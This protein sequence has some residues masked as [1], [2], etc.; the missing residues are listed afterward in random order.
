MGNSYGYVIVAL[1]AAG[2][3]AGAALYLYFNLEN[4]ISVRGPGVPAAPVAS[5]FIY[6]FNTGGRLN[7]AG[8]MGESTSPYWWLDSGG[9]LLL[10]NGTGATM[11]GDTPPSDPWFAEYADTNPVDTDNGLHP[12]NI[13][14]LVTRSVS[15]SDVA[16]QAG[17][18]IAK[19]NFSASPNRNSSNGLLL[20]SR[21][22]D[23]QTLYYAGI[24][25]DGTAVIKRKYKGTYYTLAQEPA[26]P[27]TYRGDV[28]EKNLLPHD[29]WIYL[30]SETRT[31][32]DQSVTVSLYMRAG[33]QDKWTLLLSAR[34]IGQGGD[35][36]ITGAGAVGI[37]TD[38][39]DVKFET[40]RAEAL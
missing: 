37:R 27:G 6:T 19:D 17:F 28:D 39:M 11:Q 10:R 3:I 12:Q 26:L 14:R 13:F 36:A 29:A 20:F 40:F 8:S 5:P 9:E 2:L 1:F 30:R 32:V 33:P 4:S 18:Y 24:R 34:D 35:P 7:E 38:F 16:V 15:W 22:K 31:N 21:Y 23:G 25:V